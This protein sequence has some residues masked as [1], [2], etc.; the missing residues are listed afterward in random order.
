MMV[1]VFLDV[2]YETIL[3]VDDFVC[4]VGHTAF[5]SHYDNGNA[6]VA[7]EIF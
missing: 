6:F 4:L 3:D 5:V 2:T 7:V 1:E